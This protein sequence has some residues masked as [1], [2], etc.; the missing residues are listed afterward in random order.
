M[1]ISPNDENVESEEI[2]PE[3]STSTEADTYTGGPETEIDMWL[4]W[5]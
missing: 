5:D 4:R 1:E 3:T 2:V